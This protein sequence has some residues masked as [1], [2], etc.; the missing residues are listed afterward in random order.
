MVFDGLALIQVRS[1]QR[2][3]PRLPKRTVNGAGSGRVYARRPGGITG[4]ERCVRSLCA[5]HSGCRFEP[6]WGTF[7]LRP[8]LA[9]ENGE[10]SAP[11]CRSDQRGQDAARDGNEHLGHEQHECKLRRSQPA[12]HARHI[13]F[14]SRAGFFRSGKEHS[15]VWPGPTWKSF[16]TFK[17]I[18]ILLFSVVRRR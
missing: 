18:E 12:P 10:S 6:R 8:E 16:K 5:P 14:S 4:S 9:G 17:S 1:I 15:S 3:F 2:I 7:T 11:R 13:C